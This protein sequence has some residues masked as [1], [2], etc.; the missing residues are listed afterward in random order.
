MVPNRAK[1]HIFD[2]FFIWKGREEELLSFI[3]D[4]NKKHPSFKFDFKYTKTVVEFLD[5]KIYKD[6]NGKLF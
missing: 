1:H 5:T 3:E 4:L 6:T 2:L